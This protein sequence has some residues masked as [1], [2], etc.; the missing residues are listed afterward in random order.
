MSSEY[1]YEV[2]SNLY[3]GGWRSADYNQLITEYD[4]S[5]EEATAICDILESFE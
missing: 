2:A 5:E 4:F 3:D 1:L